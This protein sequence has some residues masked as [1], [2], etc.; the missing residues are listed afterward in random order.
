V[1]PPP[2]TLPSLGN[3]IDE[4]FERMTELADSDQQLGS[5]RAIFLQLYVMVTGAVREKVRQGDYFQD[6]IWASRYLVAF[7]NLYAAARYRYDRGEAVPKSWRIAFQTADNRSGLVLQDL[8]LGV[9]AHINHDL[10]PALIEATIDPDRDRRYSDHNAVNRILAD[11]TNASQDKIAA[12]YAPGLAAADALAG[13]LDE[14]ASA[15]SIEH[16]RENA[17]RHAVALAAARSGFE[18]GLVKTGLDLQSAVL[19]RLILAPVRV[20]PGLRAA[21]ATVEQGF[22]LG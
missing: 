18:Q 2:L 3:N 12:L 10:A 17:W 21:F 19:A 15:F 9:N 20:V 5:R 13:P 14:V 4:V 7:A 8:L 16:A 22:R 6:S 11:L 1:R